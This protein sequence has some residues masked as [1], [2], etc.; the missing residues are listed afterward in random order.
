V[1]AAAVV[2]VAAVVSAGATIAVSA[3]TAVESAPSVLG[4]EEH[5][6]KVS[7]APTKTSESTFFISFVVF[8]VRVA[9]L[10]KLT[11][12]QVPYSNNFENVLAFY[13]N[14]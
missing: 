2:S 6:A 7:I 3:D 12:K 1:S 9:N 11:K 14:A 13:K 8:K 5:A 10:D 4:F